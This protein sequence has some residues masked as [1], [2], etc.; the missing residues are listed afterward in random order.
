MTQ[1][2]FPSPKQ[3][4]TFD[5]SLYLLILLLCYST[6]EVVPIQRERL[7]VVTCFSVRPRQA[8]P[9]HTIDP[10]TLSPVTPCRYSLELFVAST[11][12]AGGACLHTESITKISLWA[13]P[14]Q[15]STL[16]LPPP[17]L[18]TV[19][20]STNPRSL[21]SSHNIHKDRS[22]IH[23]LPLPSHPHATRLRL[24]K[25]SHT[26]SLSVGI[27]RQ[28]GLPSASYIARAAGTYHKGVSTVGA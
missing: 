5:H 6:I 20:T 8:L 3:L 9:Y 12:L 17:F 10:P 1:Q 24:D 19:S 23:P 21:C 11:T 18:S 27:R 7:P 4:S 2:I 13:L 16:D 22:L 14:S 15:K 25:H 28:N 26:T